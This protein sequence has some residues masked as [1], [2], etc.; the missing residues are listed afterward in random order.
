M[1]QQVENI[2]SN[3]DGQQ[4][5]Q[6]HIQWSSQDQLQDISQRS[7]CNDLTVQL[8]E[9]TAQEKISGLG[10]QSLDN[11]QNQLRTTMAS[12]DHD[13]KCW[14]EKWA[15]SEEVVAVQSARIQHLEEKPTTSNLLNIVYD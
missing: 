12:L 13:R 4:D 14:T 10:Y 2:R 8:V 15:Q 6:D 11:F 7:N 3:I 1:Q 9:P 5:E